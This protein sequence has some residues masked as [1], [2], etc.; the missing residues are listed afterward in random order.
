MDL[1]QDPRY[2]A[3]IENRTFS[4]AKKLLRQL[5]FVRKL[6]PNL[7]LDTSKHL[8]K[9]IEKRVLRSIFEVKG[10]RSFYWDG[11]MKYADNKLYQQ[12]LD[13]KHLAFIEFHPMIPVNSFIEMIDYMYQRGAEFLG[14]KS[15]SSTV[16]VFVKASSFREGLFLAMGENI[17]R[18]ILESDKLKD[19]QNAVL[20]LNRVASRAIVH[21][22]VSWPSQVN[23]DPRF[24][25][26]IARVSKETWQEIMECWVFR[27]NSL[28]IDHFFRLQLWL[29]R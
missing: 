6:D 26:Q 18:D 15:A 17:A 19:L 10:R 24:D 25:G 29:N 16:A 11:R 21:K 27:I 4:G 7:E 5:E 12:R 2:K 14:V 13:N 28:V 8:L 3:A 22:Q 1:L 9:V 23:T 20:L